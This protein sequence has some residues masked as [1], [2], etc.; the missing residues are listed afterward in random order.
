MN[1]K[2]L[3]F[4]FI[5][6]GLCSCGTEQLYMTVNEP[7]PVTLPKTIKKVGILNRS[8]PADANKVMN[9]IDLILSEK[10][11]ELDKE[12]SKEGIRGLKDA[13]MENARFTEVVVLDQLDI[14]TPAVGT[15]PTAL[16]WD[17]IETICKTNQLDALFVLEMFETD[18]KITYMPVPVQVATPFGQVPAIEHDASMLT[19]VKTGW[20]IYDPGIR[21]IADQFTTSKSMTFSSRGI[22]PVAA[23]ATLLSRKDAVNQTG[24]LGGKHSA[25]RILPYRQRVYRDY[26]VNGSYDFKIAKRRA[27]TGNWDGAAEIWLKETTNPDPKIQGRAFYN[28]A[29]I[30]EMNGDLDKAI[31]WAARAYENTNNKLALRYL[32]VLKNRKY[33]MSK[34][35]VQEEQ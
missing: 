15:F 18:S 32:N 28:M 3:I 26:Y 16:S 8:R 14:R 13:L 24:Y 11:P 33:L 31:D 2:V 6:M 12:G 19:T 9:T 34:L 4:L 25:A 23:A 5:A 1:K 30:N 17:V 29:I 35:R 27:R 22:N 21:F 10:G 7:A 20:R